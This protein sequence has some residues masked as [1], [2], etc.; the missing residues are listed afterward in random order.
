M[1]HHPAFLPTVTC[2]KKGH[3][4]PNCFQGVAWR[5]A[6]EDSRTGLTQLK[7]GSFRAWSQLGVLGTVKTDGSNENRK[8]AAVRQSTLPGH[9]ARMQVRSPPPLRIHAGIFVPDRC[10]T[11]TGT[12][13]GG[14]YGDTQR[15]RISSRGE[16]VC[17]R[18]SYCLFCYFH[19]S[20]RSLS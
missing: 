2:Y 20:I 12:F 13:F 5:P 6:P 16:S 15:V 10:R 4:V 9:N 1:Q 18:L 8:S 3:E 11:H 17:D 19:F 7:E 14:R